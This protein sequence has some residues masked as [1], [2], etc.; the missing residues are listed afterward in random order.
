M[1]KGFS[2]KVKIK[3][4][5]WSDRHCCLCGKSCGVNI[6]VHHIVQPEDGGTDDLDNALPLC[7]DCHASVGAYS[8]KHP[9]GS[10]YREKE[11][12]ARRDQIYEEYTRHL[13][14][15][16][17][18]E[19]TQELTNSPNGPKRELPDVGF[20]IWHYGD[21]LPVR[22]KVFVNV[23]LAG[24]HICT[25]AGHYSGERL[26][27]MNPRFGVRGHFRIPEKAVKS[28]EHL[29]VRVTAVIIDQY[30]REHKLLP[31]GYVFMRDKN[32][33]HLEP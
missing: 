32:A 23:L 11:L 13:A 9:R 29:E 14:P 31:V 33:W 7:F 6:E 28:N 12:K 16:I 24:K 4:L 27:N 18:F 1:G 2:D 8:N 17:F 10:K 19:V 15:P 20:N 21:S 25:P 26:W 5:L 30:E 22:L 3:A